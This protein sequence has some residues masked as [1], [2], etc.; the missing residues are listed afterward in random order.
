MSHIESV[1][2]KCTHARAHTHG[3]A[4]LYYIVD[5]KNTQTPEL[6]IGVQQREATDLPLLEDG[7]EASLMRAHSVL[8]LLIQPAILFVSLSVVLKIMLQPTSGQRVAVQGAETQNVAHLD[9]RLS[10]PVAQFCKRN[11]AVHTPDSTNSHVC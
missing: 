8:Y 6:L 10:I 5:S 4:C 11:I 3:F 9:Q 1:R 2:S 7:R